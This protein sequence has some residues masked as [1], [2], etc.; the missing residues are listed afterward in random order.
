MPLRTRRDIRLLQLLPDSFTNP[1]IYCIITSTTIDLAE[2]K[3]EALSYTWGETTL[4]K[5]IY[6][7]HTNAQIKVSLNCYNALRHLR[8]QVIT[9]TLWIDAICINQENIQERGSQV[10]IMGEI[11]SASANTVVF[12]GDSTPESQ[13]LFQ[14]LAAADQWIKSDDQNPAN[15]PELGHD[16]ITEM[17]LLLKRAW[18]TRIWVIQEL[19]LSPRVTF[20]CGRDTATIEAFS[21]FLYRHEKNRRAFRHFPV[22]MEL[23]DNHFKAMLEDGLTPVQSMFLYVVGA[24]TCEST[25]SRDQ[26]LALTPLIDNRPLGLETL[27]NYDRSVNSLFY[28]FALL[29]LSEVGLAILSTIRHPHPGDADPH[30]PRDTD[31]TILLPS[32][33]PDWTRSKERYLRLDRIPVFS[34][35][36]RSSPNY[37]RFHVDSSNKLLVVRGFR[38]G[39]VHELGPVIRIDQTDV[40]TRIEAV[41]ALVDDLSAMTDGA[42]L[43]D[44][45]DSIMQCEYGVSSSLIFCA[46]ISAFRDNLD[47]DDL[48]TLLRTCDIRSV[49]AECGYRSRNGLFC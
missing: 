38:H 4:S 10:Q 37:R 2:Y 29:L 20:M 16:I 27:I 3:F 7:G 13:V 9:R 19:I 30:P 18:F 48:S 36:Y 14:H 46:N 24:N 17:E 34:N 42:H 32:W 15:P 25:D 41:R 6:C 31:N 26:I 47:R 44:W 21:S 28:E 8:D 11:F 39:F 33:V 1:D 23:D 35:A 5:T 43:P 12:L 40:N 22:P 49:S 45:P